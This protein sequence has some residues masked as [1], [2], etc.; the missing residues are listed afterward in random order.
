MI[1]VEFTDGIDWY[2]A[3]WAFR[4]LAE[5]TFARFPDD[6]ELH[7]VLEMAHAFN[8]LDFK[9]RLK[10][11]KELAARTLAALRTVAEET[12]KGS[13]HGLKG[14]HSS[15]EN[16]Q[17]LY[18]QSLKELIILI[19]KQQERDNLNPLYEAPKHSFDE[20]LK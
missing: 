17:Q 12:L 7:S 8:C 4:Q 5:D 3:N 6:N 16:R 13:I 20:D 10:E 9:V 11:N 14:K 1:I 19:E 15:D 18:L 2:K